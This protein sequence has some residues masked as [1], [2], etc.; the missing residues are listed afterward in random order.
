MEHTR[1]KITMAALAGALLPPAIAYLGYLAAGTPHVDCGDSES[2]RAFYR[3][4]IPFFVLAGLVGAGALVLVAR[5]RTEAKRHL[6]A[7]SLAVLTGIVALDALMPGALNHP[8]EAI[9]VVLGLAALVGGV[10]TLPVTIGLA[11]VAG[12]KLVRG[13]DRGTP[14][15]KERRIY[16]LLIGWVL[17]TALP[18]LIVGVSLNAD[19]LCFS[20]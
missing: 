10:L 11:A 9:V 18:A 7:E 19:P 5:A 12:T 4:G 20:F 14:D 16:L 1:R 6:I 13:R 3:V 8:A 2:T 15:R 17:L